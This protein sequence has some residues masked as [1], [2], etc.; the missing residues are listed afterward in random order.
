MSEAFDPSRPAEILLKHHGREKAER[1]CDQNILACDR[2][3]D[4]DGY[5][6]WKQIKAALELAD[7]P[8]L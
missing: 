1:L 3:R 2:A 6:Q 7:K 5:A 8:L 4:L